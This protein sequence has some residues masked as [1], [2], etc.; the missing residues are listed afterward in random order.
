MN[1]D[2]LEKVLGIRFRNRELW[3]SAITH[4]SYLNEDRDHPVPNYER[5][6]C[7]GDAVL[8]LAV[9]EHLYRNYALREENITNIRSAVVNY[10]HMAAI[11]ANLGLGPLILMSKGQSRE[12]GKARLVIL[13]SCLEAVIGAMYFDAGYKA[14]YDFINQTV[15]VELPMII[16]GHRWNDSKSHLQEL[17]QSMFACLPTYKV[18]EETGSQHNRHFLV[19]VYL[20]EVEL[21]KGKGPSKKEAELDA[22]ANAIKSTDNL[23][24][25]P[26]RSLVAQTG[27]KSSGGR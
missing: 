24:I 8:E 4:R 17:T 20:Q 11:A 27:V 15:L 26:V 22:A 6:E 7:L 18:L 19:A 12:D 10:K 5:L 16:Q 14:C 3:L 9:T 23:T 2:R 1:L 25:G 21:A 13:C